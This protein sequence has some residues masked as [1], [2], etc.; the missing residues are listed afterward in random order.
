MKTYIRFQEIIKINKKTK[1]F[2]IINNTYNNV[3]G[4]IKWNSKWRQYCFYPVNETI[5]SVGCLNDI[6]NQ[7]TELMN[8]R[9]NLHN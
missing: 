2:L 6:N 8:E 3:L 4:E 5:F 1:T 7:I 9:K